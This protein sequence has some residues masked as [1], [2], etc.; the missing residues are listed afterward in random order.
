MELRKWQKEAIEAWKKTE[1]GTWHVCTGAGKTAGAVEIIKEIR[2]NVLVMVHQENLLK[3]W[4]EVI[5]SEIPEQVGVYYGKLKE[6][7]RITIALINSIRAKTIKD[8][9]LLIADEIHHYT[10]A[11]N[12]KFFLFNNFKKVLGL[13]ATPQVEDPVEDYILKLAPVVY[14]YSKEQAV[15]DGI[16][17][18]YTMINIPVQLNHAE[19]I[20]YNIYD[21]M[22]KE[23]MM[24]FNYDIK[25]IFKH[26][27]AGNGEALGVI[28]AIANRK[29]IIFRTEA[30]LKE[31][32]EIIKRHPDNKIIIFDERVAVLQRLE[33]H[34]CA[35]RIPNRSYHSGLSKKIK[36]MGMSDFK[37][38]KVNIML[39]AKCFDEG[40]DIPQVD[41]GIIVNGNSTQRQFIQRLGRILRLGE[42][43]K[44][45]VVYQIFAENTVDEKW[46][47]KRSS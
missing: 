28:K 41:M 12:S 35:E 32:V 2:G 34:L 43:N 39:T 25:A 13:S 5:E 17:C 31:T 44:K 10:S 3:Q 15:K 11:V 18:D 42:N 30:K 4:R 23:G 26:G 33:S 38:G 46:V 40:I 29:E 24:S 36:E 14:T 22:V 21:R 16:L 45:P 47:K 1:K 6:P 27:N 9:E 7:R 37:S 20:S 8:C 19:K